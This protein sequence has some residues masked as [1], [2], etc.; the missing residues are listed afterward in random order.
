MNVTAALRTAGEELEL[1]GI[2][3]PRHEA[4]SL[5]AF[6]IKRDRTFLFAHPEYVLTNDESRLYSDAISRRSRREPFQYIVGKQDFY[7]LEFA[8]DHNVLIPRPET[9]IL[10]EAAIERLSTLSSPRFLEIGIGSGCITHTILKHIPAATAV[11]VDISSAALAVARSNAEAHGVERRVDLIVADIYSAFGGQRFDA[12]V[13]N[14]PYVESDDI[15]GL[16]PEVR[17]YEP[18]IALTDGGNGLSIIERII[19]GAGHFLL[20]NGFLLVEIG[21]GQMESV[22]TVYDPVIWLEPEFIDDQQGIP[23]IALSVRRN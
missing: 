7:G 20:P 13:T 4:S 11:G 22:K 21:F 23:R 5:L 10:V 6:A 16:Q 17:L 15:G 8:V 1:S 2:D 19:T 14:P 9:E 18:H 12:I 3:R